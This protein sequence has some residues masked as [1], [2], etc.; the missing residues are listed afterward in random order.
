MSATV[1]PFKFAEDLTVESESISESGTITLEN[2]GRMTVVP[3]L[4]TSAPIAI[5]FDDKTVNVNAGTFT[6]AGLEI[7]YNETMEISI[8]GTA[9]VSFS[10]REATL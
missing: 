6:I 2:H 3:E 8:T 10:Y 5:S 1:F 4:T 9:D 7:G